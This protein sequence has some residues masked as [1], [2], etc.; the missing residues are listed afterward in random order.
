MTTRQTLNMVKYVDEARLAPV[1]VSGSTLQVSRVTQGVLSFDL[2]EP[3][4]ATD[5]QIAEAGIAAML[6]LVGEDP[7]RVGLVDTPARVVK[8]FREM[9]DR[10]GDPSVFMQRQFPDAD[11]PIDQMIAVGPIEF[12]S[13]CEH[14]LLPFLGKAWIAYIPVDG[15]IGL[16]KVPRLLEHYARRPQ[17]QERLTSQVGRELEKQVPNRGVGV[18]LSASHSCSALRGVKRAAPMTT[19]YLTGFFRDD[20]SSRQEFMALTGAGR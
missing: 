16:S 5:Q 20:P 14:H 4:E 3:A 6:R 7:T 10:P 9:C 13:V 19:S 12:T 18:V 11:H 17:V 8:A 1:R 2:G 15:V